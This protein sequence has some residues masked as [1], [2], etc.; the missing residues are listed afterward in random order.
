MKNIFIVTSARSEFGILQNII[1]ELFQSKKVKSNLVVTGI[2]LEKKFGKTVD[3]ISKLKITRVVKIK[4]KN[5]K[6]T[7]SK[8]S[9]LV[10]SELIDKFNLMILKNK[11][12]SVILFGD[13]FEILAIA[14]TFFLHKIPIIPAL[15]FVSSYFFLNCSNHFFIMSS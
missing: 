1:L 15:L 14:Y 4:I 7:S 6:K 11:I 5:L 12:D 2:H 8:N 13:R 3:E 9:S 10:A